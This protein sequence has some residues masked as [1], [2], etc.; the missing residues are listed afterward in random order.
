MS[1]INIP[2]GVTSIGN[3]A[4]VSCS[5]LET[6]S[7]P[8]SLNYIGEDAFYDCPNVC[9]KIKNNDYVRDVAI[10][11]DIRSEYVSNMGWLE[12]YATPA[13]KSNNYLDLSVEGV[14]FLQ[15][16]LYDLGIHDI[17]YAEKGV[18]DEVTENAVRTFQLWVNAQEGE[19][20][21]DVNGIFDEETKLYLKIALTEGMVVNVDANLANVSTDEPTTEPTAAPETFYSENS[22][23]EI[24]ESPNAP[25]VEFTDKQAEGSSIAVDENPITF[26]Q[27]FPQVIFDENGMKIS[28]IN[29][30]RYDWYADIVYAIE[31][32]RDRK[33]TRLNSSHSGESR[34]PSSA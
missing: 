6:V 9:L 33:S 21:L 32:N 8:D 16:K 28:V 30:V 4:F 15:Q 3:E 1:S 25:S 34:M 10:E 5:Y 31:N 14:S 12:E 2:E 7:I 24:T 27:T 19:Y 29:F 18:Y 26:E 13:P 17:I 20:V 23:V 11:N 22:I